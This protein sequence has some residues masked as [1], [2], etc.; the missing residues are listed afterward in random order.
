MPIQFLAWEAES[1][2]NPNALGGYVDAE[3]KRL[4]WIVG[5]DMPQE[6]N[7]ITLSDKKDKWGL[8]VV[9][10]KRPLDRTGRSK[11]RK[12]AEFGRRRRRLRCLG[13]SQDD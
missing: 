5:E 4:P 10:G 1:S 12:F 13:R 2:F 9:D 8:P 11:V 7:R 6:T 3:G